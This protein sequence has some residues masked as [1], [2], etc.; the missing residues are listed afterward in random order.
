M[1]PSIAPTIL[2]VLSS[3]PLAADEPG[4]RRAVVLWSDGSTGEALR[5][6]EDEILICEGDHGN[7]RLMVLACW[8]AWSSWLDRRE[9]GT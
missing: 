9:E 1:I 7:S 5:W 8:D 4:S 3:E 2:E 6:Y